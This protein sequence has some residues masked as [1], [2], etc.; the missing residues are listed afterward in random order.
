MG[1]QQITNPNTLSSLAGVASPDSFTS[2]GAQWLQNVATDFY[3]RFLDNEAEP[4]GYDSIVE[5]ATEIVP[6]YSHE[7]WLVFVDLCAYSWDCDQVDRSSGGLEGDLTDQAGQVLS[8]I[9]EF[10]ITALAAALEE[11]RA[12]PFTVV[13]SFDYVEDEN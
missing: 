9:A 13:G 4:L 2:P 8:Y 7:R 3:E 6:V 11:D 5:C 12:E 1:I 10:L